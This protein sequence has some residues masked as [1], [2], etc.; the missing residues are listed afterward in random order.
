M[1][2]S[3]F[4]AKS[5]RARC[6]TRKPVCDFAVYMLCHEVMPTEL[7]AQGVSISR[8]IGHLVKIFANYVAFEV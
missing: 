8:S 4:T 6:I 5:D 2:P 7:R 3:R 1:L